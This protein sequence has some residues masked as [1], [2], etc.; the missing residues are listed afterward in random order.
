MLSM[1]KHAENIDGKEDE[2]SIDSEDLARSDISGLIAEDD[3]GSELTVGEVRVEEGL[4]AAD[5]GSSVTGFVVNLL[6]K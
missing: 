6:E 5:K 2:R 1:N 3:E 4:T